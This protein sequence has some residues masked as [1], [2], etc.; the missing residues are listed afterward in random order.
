MSMRRLWLM[1]AG[2]RSLLL[3]EEEK[4]KATQSCRLLRASA[5]MRV[6]AC[7]RNA[8]PDHA[9]GSKAPRRARAL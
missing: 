8:D 4:K 3:D 1:V 9:H 5:H 6:G 7:R 2:C